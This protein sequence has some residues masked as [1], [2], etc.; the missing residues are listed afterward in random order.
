[1]QTQRGSIVS[2]LPCIYFWGSLLCC[3]ARVFIGDINFRQNMTGRTSISTHAPHSHRVPII[4][5][6]HT[7]AATIRRH[8]RVVQDQKPKT[9]PIDVALPPWPSARCQSSGHPSVW[10]FSALGSQSYE[11][12]EL[13]AYCEC[14]LFLN[15]LFYLL[16][17][18]LVN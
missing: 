2:R 7:S 1:M 12:S 3:G 5:K 14:R 16:C 4:L 10:V 11:F 18:L 17:I 6:C 9:K 13:R 15:A 8:L